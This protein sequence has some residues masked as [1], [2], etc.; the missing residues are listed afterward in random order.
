MGVVFLAH[1]NPDILNLDF[2]LIIFENV[3][4]LELDMEE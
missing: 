1:L 4:K 2:V 3:F